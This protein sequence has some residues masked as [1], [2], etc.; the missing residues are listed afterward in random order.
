MST[1]LYEREEK[2]PVTTTT[3][4]PHTQ[5]NFLIP[6]DGNNER[7][8]QREEGKTFN[9]REKKKMIGKLVNDGFQTLDL[10]FS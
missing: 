10:K 8:H 3:C 5:H 9:K 2:T 1:N 6:K 7:H 4:K